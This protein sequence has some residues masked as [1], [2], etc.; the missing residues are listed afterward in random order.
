M[1]WKIRPYLSVMCMSK[2]S[3]RYCQP[4]NQQI[5][6]L[7]NNFRERGSYDANTY[8]F[9]DRYFAEQMTN[10]AIA[11][12]PCS[13]PLVYLPKNHTSFDRLDL[14]PM[15]KK[16]SQFQ[17]EAIALLECTTPIPSEYDLWITHPL[18]FLIIWLL[19]IF[20]FK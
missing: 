5:H 18:L 7:F 19:N 14:I 9:D 11:N 12:V 6:L 13:N 4:L 17:V 8:A 3:W 10:V 15:Y 2:Y 16:S 1:I 20:L